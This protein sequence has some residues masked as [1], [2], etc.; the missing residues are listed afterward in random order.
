MTHV[1]EIGSVAPEFALETLDG[2]VVDLSQLKGQVVLLDFW[3]TSCPPCKKELPAIQA[4]YEEYGKDGLVVLT[5]SKDN[6]EAK[7]RSF[8]EEPGYTFPCA[9]EDEAMTESYGGGLVPYVVLIDRKGI[10]RY[11]HRGYDAGDE[12][13]LISEIE[14]L[15]AETSP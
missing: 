15:L 10:V 8:L 4:I 14:N 5:I 13:A 11:T 1:L 3:A 7:V 12:R 6:D 2:E 9:L